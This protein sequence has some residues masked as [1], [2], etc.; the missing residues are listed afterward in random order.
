MTETE[1]VAAAYGEHHIQLVVHIPGVRDPI[2]DFTDETFFPGGVDRPAQ[3]DPAINGG[4]L[5]VFGIHGHSAVSDDFPANLRLGVRV[6]PAVALSARG[7]RAPIAITNTWPGVVS[8]GRRVG[9]EPRLNLVG[10]IN[11]AGITGL[12]EIGH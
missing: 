9:V 12:A 2:R 8:A 7:Q 6:G 3:D 5:H 1:S 11:S 10:V 4:D